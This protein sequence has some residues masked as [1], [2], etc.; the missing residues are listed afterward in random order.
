MHPKCN[1]SIDGKVRP[2]VPIDDNDFDI[3]GR[4]ADV[5]LSYR[6]AFEFTRPSAKVIGDTSCLAGRH[7]KSCLK[8]RTHR[9]S[10]TRIIHLEIPSYTPTIIEASDK[11]V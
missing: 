8:V 5:D 1:Q 10:L 6:S 4:T 9:D 2:S 11:V 3:S 7:L